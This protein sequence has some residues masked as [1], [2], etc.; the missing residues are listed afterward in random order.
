MWS[1]WF[2]QQLKWDIDV[3]L[4]FYGGETDVATLATSPH[5]FPDCG[6]LDVL[7]YAPLNYL[8]V[9]CHVVVGVG[10]SFVIPNKGVMGFSVQPSSRAIK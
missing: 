6:D 2:H 10:G 1:P 5:Y 4:F 7:Y 3:A 9:R 8:D